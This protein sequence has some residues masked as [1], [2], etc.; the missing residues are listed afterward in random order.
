[1]PAFRS[2]D[3]ANAPLIAAAVIAV[4]VL[5][6]FITVGVAAGEYLGIILIG[7]L[8]LGGLFVAVRYGGLSLRG[9]GGGFRRWIP[10]LVAAIIVVAGVAVVGG[11]T[12]APSTWGKPDEAKP[13]DVTVKG[14][15]FV[16]HDTVGADDG[17]ISGVTVTWQD[18][19]A[20]GFSFVP[21]C[22]WW[23]FESDPI[24]VNVRLVDVARVQEDYTGSVDVGR[25]CGSNDAAKPFTVKI[26]AVEPSEYTVYLSATNPK[27]GDVAQLTHGKV[28]IQHRPEAE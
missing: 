18:A 22:A 17:S 5:G 21:L 12:P 3:A 16:D 11:A 6:V 23:E 13:Q 1:M 8:A 14:L 25:F 27:D 26:P 4:A 10:A 20:L 2:D 15:V 9:S 24:T 19:R 7:G 28:T